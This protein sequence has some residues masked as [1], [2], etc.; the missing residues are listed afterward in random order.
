MKQRLISR[1]ITS[2]AFAACR[3]GRI[4]SRSTVVSL[5]DTAETDFSGGYQTR[6]ASD[7]GRRGGRDRIRNSG[8]R[9]PIARVM[10]AV[11]KFCVWALAI[12]AAFVKILS[13]PRDGEIGKGNRDRQTYEEPFRWPLFF[14]DSKQLR[15]AR[16]L[17]SL[18]L[19]ILL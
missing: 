3:N 13:D 2:A 1:F 8:R 19:E 9:Q 5:A 6:R 15:G 11:I 10:N 4:Y 14:L 18:D 16:R 12:R 17:E 7:V